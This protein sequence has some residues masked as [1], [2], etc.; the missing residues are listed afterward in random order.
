MLGRI[1]LQSLF[2]ALVSI[3][4]YIHNPLISVEQTSVSEKL[5][6]TSSSAILPSVDQQALE[7]ILK[8]FDSWFEK[9]LPH[10]EHEGEAHPDQPEFAEPPSV[11]NMIEM[12]KKE[13]SSYTAITPDIRYLIIEAYRVAYE[14]ERADYI[15]LEKTGEDTSEYLD[16]CDCHPRS[17]R[18]ALLIKIITQVTQQ[19]PTRNRKVIVAILAPGD[20]LQEY[21][22]VHLLI[23]ILGYQKVTL[24]CIDLSYNDPQFDPVS[25]RLDK[26]GN[27]IGPRFKKIP[28][29]KEVKEKMSA[30]QKDRG[31]QARKEAL[32]DYII[33]DQPLKRLVTLI[34]KPSFTLEYFRHSYSYLLWAKSRKIKAQIIVMVDPYPIGA[35]LTKYYPE[36]ET[37]FKTLTT[38]E[39]FATTYP[40]ANNILLCGIRQKI[41]GFW[42]GFPIIIIHPQTPNAPSIL[43]TQE[44]YAPDTT[45]PISADDPAQAALYKKNSL[46]VK[47][48]RDIIKKYPHQPT[49]WSELYQP[50]YD[51]LGTKVPVGTTKKGKQRNDII[52]TQEQAVLTCDPYIAFGDIAQV[53]G[54]KNTIAY[55]SFNVNTPPPP[56]EQIWHNK[57][58]TKP[59]IP[60]AEQKHLAAGILIPEISDYLRNNGYVAVWPQP[61]T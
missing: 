45:T 28:S 14:E 19:F 9:A 11:E 38:E 40:G 46:A 55:W 39:S 24:H 41:G 23:N 22:L 8:K 54:E 7:I 32:K 42:S 26:Q 30:S 18:I 5:H 33:S 53:I 44:M 21:V 27:I 59:Y 15:Y 10:E 51:I 56:E 49:P 3:I 58:Y 34:N 37:L 16:W 57:I 29:E 1:P 25:F 35:A 13:L 4:M 12:M 17:L 50:L 52:L 2:I 48:L 47:T 43:Y 61:S 60:S 36:E 6:F 31:K 20:L